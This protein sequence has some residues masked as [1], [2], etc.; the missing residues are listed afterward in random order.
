MIRSAVDGTANRI[1]GLVS[2]GRRKRAWLSA[3]ALILT[4]VVAVGY[5][6][7]GALRVNPFASTYRVTVKL[8]E[9]GTCYHRWERTRV[10]TPATPA[11]LA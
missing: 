10:P 4:M 3:G 11:A 1:V 9:S 6:L 2:Y 7:F 8:P 5:L